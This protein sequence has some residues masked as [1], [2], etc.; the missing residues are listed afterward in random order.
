MDA[1]MKALKDMECLTA[2]QIGDQSISFLLAR[3]P[4]FGNSDLCIIVN[5]NQAVKAANLLA[6]SL[7]GGKAKREEDTRLDGVK[8]TYATVTAEAI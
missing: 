1:Q 5:G 2:N 4:M 6:A 3:A 7:K 8:Y